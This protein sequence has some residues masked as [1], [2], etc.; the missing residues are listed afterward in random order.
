MAV[1]I[2]L[3]VLETLFHKHPSISLYD[4]R[5]L[6]LVQP[7]LL[8]SLCISFLVQVV[9]SHCQHQHLIKAKDK[10]GPRSTA[11]LIS[12]PGSF[13]QL[14]SICPNTNLLFFTAKV[15]N[16]ENKKKDADRSIQREA[17]F[18]IW[19][20]SGPRGSAC[21]QRP[22]QNPCSYFLDMFGKAGKRGQWK[23]AEVGAEQILVGNLRQSPVSLSASYVAV[24]TR[25]VFTL[26]LSSTHD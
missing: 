14:L 10:H 16:R 3:T 1:P 26:D 15:K 12:S 11:E 13:S 21:P 20:V 23:T 8:L 24:R 4:V 9:L 22:L 19:L 25:P 6:F 17:I 5:L 7:L 2:G 18:R